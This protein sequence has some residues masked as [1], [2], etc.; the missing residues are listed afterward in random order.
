MDRPRA[1]E[2]FAGIGL[3]RSALED[4]GFSVVFANDIEAAKRDMYA[5][6]FDA[7]HFVCGDVRDVRGDDVPDIDLATAS[8]PCTDLSLAGNR[9]GLAGTQ[10]SMFWEFARI[11]GEMR[12]RRPGV[13]L[14]ENVPSFATSH[15]GADLRAALTKLNRLGYSCDLF[16]LDAR[17]FVP[18]SRPRLFIVAAMEPSDDQAWNGE[19][20]PPWIADFAMR[21]PELQLH[22]RRLH[23]PP[24]ALRSLADIVERVRHDDPRWWEAARLA[25]FTGSLSPIQTQ[26]LVGLRSSRKLIWATAYRRTRQGRAVWEIRNDSISG[27]LRTARGGSSRQALVQTGRGG[28]RVRWMT[29]REYARL[30]GA[31][32]Y[33]LDETITVNQALFGF[34]DAVCVPVVAWIAENYIAPL[35]A[36]SANPGLLAVG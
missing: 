18:Q 1:A 32:D 13:V 4:V 12:H 36:R 25:R 8:F 26:R 9:T 5:A 6:N 15:G 2:F 24:M 30:Q 28:L 35:V 7:S 3:V 20:R 29:P 10:S 17:R 21:H 23:V 19:L 27:C 34:G 33:R 16:V 22:A 11:L 31:P 14:L